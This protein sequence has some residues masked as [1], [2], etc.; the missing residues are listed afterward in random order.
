MEHKRT[1]KHEGGLYIAICCCILVIA[2]IGYAN[3]IAE[4]N[5]EEERFLAEK[6]GENTLAEEIKEEQDNKAEETPLPI[7]A[8]VP[9]PNE[10]I[11]EEA[12]QTAKSQEAEKTALLSYPIPNGRVIGEFSDTPIYTEAIGEWRTHN[13]VDIEAELGTSVAVADDGVVRRMFD[14]SLGT[15]IEI[16]HADGLVSVYSNLDEKIT[17]KIGDSVRKGDVIGYIGN[18]ALGDI[19]DKPHLHFEVILDGEY[20]NPTDYLG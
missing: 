10:E 19:S 11:Y 12:Q 20:K 4:K 15:G 1:K 7:L 16:E 5:K 3:N 13:G 2:L 17:V 18:T 14:G 8:P 9:T 6:A